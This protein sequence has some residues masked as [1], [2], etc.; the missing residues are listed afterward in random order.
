MRT[1]VSVIGAAAENLADGVVVDP[2]RVKAYGSRIQT[3]SRRLADTVERVLLYAGIEA[4][5]AVGHR[6]PLSVAT[7]VGETI[8]SSQD[9]LSEAGV[10]LETS[11]ADDLPPVMVDAP[12]LR[13][14]LANLI[15]NAVKYGGADRWGSASPPRPGQA[16]RGPRSGSP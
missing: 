9:H 13:W 16:V 2:V 6:A 3:E 15:A 14:C 11:V 8:A 5:H 10:T 1:P 4:G 7:L 12:A